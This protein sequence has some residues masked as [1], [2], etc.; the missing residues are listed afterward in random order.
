MYA[1][2]ESFR[3]ALNNDN[4]NY[5]IRLNFTFP[6][7][8]TLQIENDAIWEGG[9]KFEDAVSSDNEFQVGSAIVN[10]MSV[11]LN[12]IYDDY[13]DYDFDGAVVVAYIGITLT[14]EGSEYI[15]RGTYIVNSSD[16]YNTSLIRLEC[17]DYM[18]K[19]DVDYA[20]IN[21]AY[22]A[23]LRTIVQNICTTCGVTLL[24]TSFRN[25]DYAVAKRPDSDGLTCR[26]ML[27]F[28]AQLA[29]SYARCD[30]YGRLDFG[31]YDMSSTPAH[32]FTGIYSI[33]TGLDAILITGVRV[34]EEFPENEQNKRNTIL[35]GNEGYVLE[36]SGNDLI[37]Q[38]EAQ[39]VAEAIGRVVVNAVPFYKVNATVLSDPSVEA[40]DV[41]EIT[42]NKG[43]TVMFPITN[44]VFE[45][46]NSMQVSCGAQD[47]VRH[48]A[49]QYSELTRA[50]VKAK[51]ISAAQI[52]AYDLAMQTLTELM[53]EAFGVFKT[54]EVQQDGSTVYIL[55]NKPNIEDS[56]IQW[57]MTANGLAVSNDY[58]ETWVAGIDSSGNAVINV[59]NAIGVNA[60]WINA[61]RLAVEDGNGN[62]VFI[63]DIDTGSVYVSGDNVFIGNQSATDALAQLSGALTVTL[64]NET[65]GI[66]VNSEGSYDTF[67][68]TSTQ[69]RVLY[70]SQDVTSTCTL[71]YSA[72]NITG[73]IALDSNLGCYVYTA[74][75]LSGDTG[76][77][78]FTAAYDPGTG[79]LRNSKRF[80]LYKVYAGATGP[81]GQGTPART[82]YIEPSAII[83][84]QGE[85]DEYLPPSVTF[86]AYYRD[87]N[88]TTRYAYTGLF[89]VEV[90]TDGSTWVTKEYP[91]ENKTS[92]TYTPVTDDIVAVRCTLYSA[93]ELN[94]T[95]YG[96]ATSSDG[97]TILT[98]NDGYL[99]LV[100][101][102]AVIVTGGDELDLQTVSV[103]RDVSSL[104]QDDVFNILTNN[105]TI[106]SIN[107]VN[108]VLYIN[109]S[110][111]ASG[112]IR[113]KSGNTY[114]NLENGGLLSIKEGEIN[115]GSGKFVVDSNGTLTATGA[116][117]SGDI[118]ANSLTL[119]GNATVPYSKVT[120]TPNLTVYVQKDGRI[121]SVPSEGAT[122][123]VVSSA[124]L[125]KASNAE[126]FGTIYSSAGKIGGWTIDGSWLRKTVEVSG[127]TYQAYLYCPTT[128]SDPA[129]TTFIGLRTSGNGGAAWTYPFAVNY[130]GKITASGTINASGG[131]I[132]GWTIDGSYLRKNATVNG[133]TYQA[134]LYCPNS[135]SN[136]SQI[137]FLGLRTST[138]GGSSWTYPF[139]VNYDGKLTATGAS[140]SGSI[141]A[142]S[143][144][145][146]AYIHVDGNSNSYFKI[147]IS[148]YYN[149]TN[150]EYIEMSG[151]GFKANTSDS[152]VQIGG[153]FDDLE[154]ASSD[155]I[156]N[157]ILLNAGEYR[158]SIQAN[159]LVVSHVGV[160]KTIIKSG[161]ID[162][163][164]L[165]V[166]NDAKIWGELQCL[167]G[168]PRIVSTEDY[169]MRYLYA[170]ETPT[171][172]FGD[173]GEGVISDDGLCY[174]RL[175]PTFAE[176][177]NTQQ[178]QV[179]LQAYGDGRCYVRERHET[180]FIV[181]GTPN[182]AFGWEIKARQVDLNSRRLERYYDKD[183]PDG[184]D[185]GVLAAEHL[186]E[187]QKERM[188]AA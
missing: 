162:V 79:T 100:E 160:V 58:G 109:A 172:M 10:K 151:Y 80:D 180:Y 185:Y 143:L 102:D 38:G 59:L 72:F 23:T 92:T 56:P 70:G 163:Y 177:I 115:L 81:A 18:S 99:F 187:I 108:G 12:N 105:R 60:S 16:G 22:P 133:V 19:F 94:T 40:G 63:A 69:I 74:S 31:W 142:T 44:V 54:E 120:G 155:D 4:R 95:F 107:L 113:S 6:D 85:N 50:L 175:D 28:V 110:Y 168:K 43:N 75:A 131:N 103:V 26:Q 112:V 159:K 130:D 57:K 68:P 183:E 129:N 101:E 55:H 17:Y 35:Y 126:I 25:W 83:L 104:S 66:P 119:S 39:T 171:P 136:P 134:Y 48:S 91:T 135:I 176:T 145:A 182:M 188:N 138:N 1:I 47:A 20:L 2:S 27:A 9:L 46:D 124:G 132:A 179:F 152:L 90:T 87:G 181:A 53:S 61:G 173:V 116:T 82:Y 156:L 67:P 49:T 8:S 153:I 118:I 174:I 157:G 84:K 178:Y 125:L 144:T 141:N 147:P 121:G 14:G 127:Q 52:S 86:S 166:H 93:A 7:T 89:K 65:Q 184:V 114:W 98:D 170:Y 30:E 64:S 45:T 41:A 24:N 150:G 123:F 77:V 73:T 161:A 186:E 5:A 11:V 3:T 62:Y 106:D 137:S 97:D 88:D 122:G 140:I 15:R 111:L 165:Y 37:Q 148:Q 51:Q 167:G 33:S 117:I 158:T 164:N 21:T 42:D 96:L 154:I 76:Y 139:S 78:T 13:T 71:T 146:D 36:I 169:G 34:T 128:V 29:A 149:M 32:S